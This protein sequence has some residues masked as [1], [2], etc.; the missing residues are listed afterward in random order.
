MKKIIAIALSVFILC[1]CLMGYLTIPNE[2]IIRQNLDVTDGQAMF[3]TIFNRRTKDL[4]VV[5]GG[6]TGNTEHVRE[7]IMKLGGHVNIWFVTHYHED[8]CGAF[9][10]IYGDPQGIVI[11][12]VIASSEDYDLFLEVY[13]D[14]DSPITFARFREL[15][16]GKENIHYPDRDDEFDFGSLH[17]KV[18]SNYDDV[19][20]D[21]IGTYDIPNNASL[22][23]KIEGKE[24]SIIFTGDMYA[25]DMGAYLINRYGDELRADYL[26]LPHHG[27]SVMT[28]DFYEAVNPEAV[29]FDAPGWLM[30]DDTY[31]AKELED[32]CN[33]RGIETCDYRTAPNELILK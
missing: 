22:V 1:F 4:I 33:E 29:L 5:D 27:N 21:T 31:R 16:E 6:W 32:W 13:K 18:F 20:T 12:H 8:H 26:Q 25:P 11:D 7:E 15:A 19:L 24:N 10:A 23:F 30:T 14:W 28:Y 3:Y 2:W 17:F 9:N